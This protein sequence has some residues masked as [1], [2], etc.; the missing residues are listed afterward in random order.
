MLSRFLVAALFIVPCLAQDA[1]RMEQ[2][3]Q[4]HLA[5]HTFMGTVLVARGTEVLF[6]KGFGF[7]DLERDVPNAPN[8]KF[9]LGS[10]TKQF[11]AASILLLEERGKLRVSDPV[12]KYMPDAPAAWDKVTI[13]HLLTHT[14][15]IP[16]FTSFPD[17]PK[18]EPFATTPEQ[19][20]ARFKDKP[21]E[22][23]PGEKWNYSNSGFVLLTYLLEK[24]SGQAYEKFVRENIFTPLGMKDSGVDSNSEVIRHRASG[25]VFNKDHFENAGFV[26]MSIPQGAG[27]LYSTTEDLLKWE[28]GLFGGKLLKAASLE[29][30]TTPFKN[31]YAFG[32]GVQTVN[33]HKEISHGGGIEGFNTFLAYYPDEKLTVVVLSNMNSGAPGEIAGKLAA[34]ARGE[35]I[36]LPGERKEITLGEDVLK[37]YAGAYQ[38]NNGPAMLVTLENNRLSGKLGNQQPLPLFPESQTMFFLKEVDAQIEFTADA[39]QLT[40]HQN[41]RDMV[42]KRLDDAAAKKLMDAAAAFQKRFKDQTAAPGGEAIVRKMIEDIRAGKPNFDLMSPG[43]ANVTRQQLPQLQG[44][45]VALGAL[46][47]VAF[48]GVGPGGADI[49]LCKFENGSIEYRIWLGVDGKLESANVRPI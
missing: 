2:V 19:L 49:Y 3:V 43:L 34:I 18:L 27:A 9:R 37:R 47:S 42:A 5:D 35:A 11:T 30:M 44:S 4:P 13:M 16:N 38:M 33:G 46:Q 28:Q 31:N 14:S 8:T 26:H 48:K 17:Y 40:L 23:E 45:M 12:K 10:V 24:I 7:A 36:K 39:S 32:V 1:A 20:V 6:S 15:G 25:Y 29:K 41:G 22:F 21:L